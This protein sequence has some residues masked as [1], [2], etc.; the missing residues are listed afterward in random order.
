MGH[1]MQNREFVLLLPMRSMRSM[2][3]GFIFRNRGPS[4]KVHHCQ[5]LTSMLQT[6]T[7]MTTNKQAMDQTILPNGDMYAT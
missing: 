5:C 6:V 1:G 4:L 2:R 7:M 3:G